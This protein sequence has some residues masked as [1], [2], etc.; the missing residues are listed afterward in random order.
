VI[1]CLTI[2]RSLA[3]IVALYDRQPQLPL[4][5]L[6]GLEAHRAYGLDQ[7]Y[8]DQERLVR[9]LGKLSLSLGRALPS[10]K[11]VCPNRRKI[12]LFYSL[13][14][15]PCRLRRAENKATRQLARAKAVTTANF[16]GYSACG[17]SF[18][19]LTASRA[20]DILPLRPIVG[21]KFKAQYY[22]P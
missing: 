19:C 18:M 12:K 10:C 21:V 7:L 13:V 9:R 8:V 6:A 20:I 4:V 17:G 14:G 3:F 16:A 2:E 1:V 11:D 5:C 15:I 22:D